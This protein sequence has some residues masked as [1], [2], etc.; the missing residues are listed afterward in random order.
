[1]TELDEHDAQEDQDLFC[2]AC[3]EPVPEWG[4]GGPRGRPRARCPRCGALERHRFLAYVLDQL[5]LFVASARAVLDIAPQRQVQHVLRR[6]APDAY[7]GTDLYD[8]LGVDLRSDITRLPFAGGAFD[9]IVCYHVLEHIGDDRAAMR[10]LARVLSPGG[11]ALIQVPWRRG[12]PT[13]ED[14]DAPAAERARRFGQDDHV[15]YYGT[16]FEARLVSAGLRPYRFEPRDLLDPAELHRLA[17]VPNEAV[18]LCRRAAPGDDGEPPALHGLRGAEP[19]LA[20]ETVAAARAQAAEAQERYDRLRRRRSVRAAL[21]LAGFT[22]PAFR[23]ARRLR[24]PPS[25]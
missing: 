24:R 13:D 8:H 20:H 6:L 17:L 22:G 15:R 4:P 19:A 16:D 14:P 23:L 12:S 9:L 18:W 11:L 2:L 21:S 25:A 3:R 7:V 10:E 1:M 5:G